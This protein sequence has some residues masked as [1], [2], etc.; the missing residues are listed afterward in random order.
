MAMTK[1]I[2]AAMNSCTSLPFE[3]FNGGASTMWDLDTNLA[4]TE[5]VS[6]LFMTFFEQGGQIFQGNMT[7]VEELR[8]AQKNPDQYRHLI[9]RVGGY[10]SRFVTLHP[11]LQNEIINRMRHN[12]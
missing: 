5:I 8:R 7:D 4:N 6:S 9:V 11:D 12:S 10:S 3:V 2:T 1:G